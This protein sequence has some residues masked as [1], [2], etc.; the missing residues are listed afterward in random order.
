MNVDASE[1]TVLRTKKI[2][3]IKYHDDS[4]IFYDNMI[5]SKFF[6]YH[7]LIKA[8]YDSAGDIVVIIASVYGALY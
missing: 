3:A 5:L 7:H 2:V 4:K 6:R 8:Q 1:T